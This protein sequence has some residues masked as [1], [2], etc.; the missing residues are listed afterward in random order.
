M[1]AMR[2]AD[3]RR[4]CTVSTAL[5]FGFA[6]V[7]F[8]VMQIYS[9]SDQPIGDAGIKELVFSKENLTAFP[10]K[11]LDFADNNDTMNRIG[12]TCSKD[13]I[14]IFQGPTTPLPNGIP[15]YTVQILNVCVS[16][17]SV[18]NIHLSCGWFSSARLINPSVFKRICYDDCLVNDGEA[19][20][21][22]GSLSFH[23][24][25]PDV[26]GA[27]KLCNPDCCHGI[28]SPSFSL[29]LSL[30]NLLPLLFPLL[31]QKTPT[32]IKPPRTRW[33]F[34]SQ[35]KL[36]QPICVLL[37]MSVDSRVFVAWEE[38]IISHEKGKR[39]VH[40]YLKDASGDLFLAVVGTERSIRHMIYVVSDEFLQAFGS[41]GSINACTKWRARREVV[42]WLTSLVL[43]HR[44]PLDISNSQ[45][46]DITQALGSNESLVAGLTALRTHL[47]DQMIQV[48]RKLKVQNSDIV[49]SG[50]TWI[51]SKQ[52]KHY[53]SFCRNGTTIAV[54]SFV[55]IMAEE[56]SHYLGY[57]E[58][59]YEDRKG[60]KK[61][62]VRWFHHNEEVEGVISELNPHPKEVFITPHVQVIS[63]E[64]IDGP[65]TVLT[66]KH[67]E[68]SL[69][70]VPQ[71]LSSG[72]HMC[73]R[74]FK[75]NKVKPFSISK[76]RGYSNQA[77]I[78]SLECPHVSEHKTKDHKSNGE[79][80]EFTHDHEGLV[81][82]VAKR[83]RSCR[84]HQRLETVNSGVM[85]P[86]PGRQM[87]K[88]EPTYQKLKIR[89][90]T[91]GPI[92]IKLVG[93]E[94]QCHVSFKVD[95][96]IELLSQ[97][98]GIRGCWFRCKVLQVS[99][100]RLKVQYND[101]QDVEESGDLEEWVPAFRVA[102]PDKLGMRCSGRLTIRPWPLEDSSDCSFEVGA[103]VDAWWSDGWWE[104]VVTGV[105]VSGS[106]NIQVYFPGEDRFLILQR[107]NIRTSRDWIGNK[108]VDIKAKPDILSYI[109]SVV[110][111]SMKH[112]MCST[113]A[114]ASE[115]GVS[116]FVDHKVL[117]NSKIEALGKDKEQLPGSAT[118]VYLDNVEGVSLGKRPRT[119]DKDKAD[120]S[121]GSGG[122]DGAGKEVRSVLDDAFQPANQKL[123]GAEAV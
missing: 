39:I 104:G 21:P 86:V 48:H 59:L 56:E 57:L 1:F 41:K 33:L 81:R 76:L 32:Q 84:G 68:K 79:E 19:L 24:S 117:T 105:D 121:C 46:N 36:S 5:G 25:S 31:K 60:Q 99:Q 27:P 110:S 89:L 71:T 88:C 44:L 119:E 74:Q 3:I 80:E 29:L 90:S 45:T 107:K 96:K 83:N 40:F 50:V 95:E 87:A 103:P 6:L 112:P 16:G 67:Y 116:A 17:C 106:G 12:A 8:F 10:R 38:H 70:V 28:H 65:A 118:S 13:D 51:C 77:I 108:W 54:H 26:I 102:S 75:N 111:P 66:P 53:P 62:K 18:S 114:E 52:L 34:S 20:S 98:S 23:S 101:V 4:L 37:R 72:I 55:F 30:Y 15:T 35:A 78:S 61:V 7:V 43:K 42:D 123:E 22:G 47:P 122:G 73:F 94:H 93:P 63:A 92:G 11:L 113:L 2:N 9:A 91:K 109:S 82:Q 97:D 85:N 115:C 100:K 64:C 14:A 120:G 58:D 49:W 69:A